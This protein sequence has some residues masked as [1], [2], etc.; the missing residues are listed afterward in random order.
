M[1]RFT[2]VDGIYRSS[3]FPGVD[4]ALLRVLV[5]QAKLAQAKGTL[6]PEFYDLGVPGFPPLSEAE[7]KNLAKSESYVYATNKQSV[8]FC[9]YLINLVV[10]MTPKRHDSGTSSIHTDE[11]GL[12]SM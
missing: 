10:S 5:K 11:V 2:L 7:K 6:L 8:L 12:T 4:P 1:S 9:P 3:Q